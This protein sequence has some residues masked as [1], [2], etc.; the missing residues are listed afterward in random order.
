VTLGLAYAQA[1]P[2]RVRAMVLMA[3]TAGTRREVEWITQDMSRVF[4]REW[5]RFA[6]L[7][8]EWE[9]GDLPTAYARLLADPDARVRDRAAREW[10]A[11]EDVHVSLAPGWAPDPR[12]DDPA[13]RGTFA[14]LVT[15]YWSADHFLPDGAGVHP[16]MARVHG[17]PAVLAHGRFDVSGPLDTA[18][19]LHRSWPGSELVV[20]GD[21][22]HGG[23]GFADA[24]AAALDRFR[25]AP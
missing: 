5:E 16:G 15:H 13:F 21:A 2:E 7:V 24:R 6:G 1:H 19:R 9:R 10:C 14:R 18:W 12:F 25:T 11:W 17:I 22:G 4:P 3:V 20:L 23:A 8:P